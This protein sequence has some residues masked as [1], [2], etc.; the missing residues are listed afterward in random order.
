[1]L[2]IKQTRSQIGTRRQH[3][4]TL[5]TLGLRKIGQSVEKADSGSVRGMLRSV[6]HLVSFEEVADAAPAKAAKPAKPAKKAAASDDKPK[7][8]AKTTAAKSTTTKKAAT[9]ATS[10]TAKKTTTRAKATSTRSRAK[11]SE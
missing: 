1:M 9:K 5:R 10:L 11:K 7:A 6:A 2:R 4:E 8:K 3:R